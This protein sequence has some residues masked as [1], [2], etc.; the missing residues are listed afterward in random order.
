MAR[1]GTCKGC[2]NKEG[3]KNVCVCLRAGE[4]GYDSSGWGHLRKNANNVLCVRACVVWVTERTR[5]GWE[6]GK[7]VAAQ[8]LER[9]KI[10]T[11][12]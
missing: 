10:V 5:S 6:V 3:D 9:S 4:T 8:T 7:P 12:D 1:I 2:V 11:D